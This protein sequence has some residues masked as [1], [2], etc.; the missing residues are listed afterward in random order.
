MSKGSLC[1][2]NKTCMVSEVNELDKLFKSVGN[3]KD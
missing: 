2:V 1:S 3:W